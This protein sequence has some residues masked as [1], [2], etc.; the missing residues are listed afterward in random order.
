M[1]YQAEIYS[2]D[3]INADFILFIDAVNAISE[4]NYVLVTEV[5]DNAVSGYSNGEE[6]SIEYDIQDSDISVGDMIVVTSIGDE[7]KSVEKLIPGSYADKAMCVQN[8][9]MYLPVSKIIGDYVVMAN[10]DT[11]HTVTTDDDTYIYAVDVSE[12]TIEE[13]E[14]SDIF[15]NP[16]DKN[17]GDWV[18][19]KKVLGTDIAQFIVIYKGM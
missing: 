9:V 16:I 19:V 2:F 17:A 10:G 12:N 6:I 11:Y 18:L 3:G 15:Y 1:T 4:Y 14:L 8:T 5:L 7:V 13:A